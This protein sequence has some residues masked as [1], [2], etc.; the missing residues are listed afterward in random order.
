M[1][2]NEILF[3]GHAV[4]R[5]FERSL[6]STEVVDVVCS[7]E[8]IAEYSDDEPFPSCLMLGFVDGRPLHVVV[9]MEFLEKTCYI[10]TAYDPHPDLWESDFRK[11][12]P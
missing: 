7:G 6:T 4:R 5:M 9:A 2:C 3:T 11:R 12:R 8:I 10:V 1:E